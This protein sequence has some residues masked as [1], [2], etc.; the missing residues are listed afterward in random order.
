VGIRE[1]WAK[2]ITDKHGRILSA[3]GAYHVIYP[4][5]AMGDRVAHLITS[6]LIDFIE[7]E[8]GFAMA[9][10]RT[11]AQAADRTLAE[12][13]L[14]TRYGTTVVGVKR[15]AR[16]SPTPARRP[17]SAPATCSSSPDARTSSSG[18]LRR[19]ET[20]RTSGSGAR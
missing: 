15:T 18:S 13:A 7:F 9:K 4:E 16:T 6:G 12:A 14:R 5:A 2:V 20:A 8:D 3:V 11:P 17:W 19:P 10:T 1:I